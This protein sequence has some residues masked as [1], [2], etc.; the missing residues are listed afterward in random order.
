MNLTLMDW[1]GVSLLPRAYHQSTFRTNGFTDYER[2]TFS[3]GPLNLTFPTGTMIRLQLRILGSSDDDAVLA[4]NST[5]ANSRLEVRASPLIR[6]DAFELRDGSGATSVWSP[7]DSLVIR[8]NVSDPF[9]VAE[10]ADVRV[11]VTAPAGGTTV[12][13]ASIPVLMTDPAALPA[14]QLRELVLPPALANG[15]Y[16]VLVTALERNGVTDVATGDALVRAPRFTLEKD[17]TAANVKAGDRFH[18]LLWYNNTGT[19]PAGSVWINDSLPV[20][21][22]FVGSSEPGAMTGS[23]NWTW[24]SVGPGSFL[25]DIEVQVR[26][27]FVDPY[28]R[29]S[30]TLE[31]VDEKGYG[32][33]GAAASVEVVLRG[34]AI[35][36]SMTLSVPEVHANEPF[37]IQFRLTNT[38]EPAQTLWLNATVP[39]G[40]TYVSDTAASLGGSRS[41]FGSTVRFVLTGMPSASIWTFTMTLAGDPLLP[42]GLTLTCDATLEFTNENGASLPSKEADL[43]VASVAPFVPAASFQFSGTA[44]DPG[45]T[46][47]A[48][49]TWTNAGNEPAEDLWINLTLDPYLGLLDA[50][51]PATVGGGSVRFHST[52]VGLGDHGTFLNLTVLS[53]VPDRRNLVVGGVLDYTDGWGNGWP[54][55]T[56]SGDLLVATAPVLGLSVS[57]TNITVEAGTRVEYSIQHANAG[58]GTT[59]DVWLNLTLPASFVYVSDTSGTFAG[60]AGNE[61]RWHWTDQGPGQRSFLL[62]LQAKASVADGTQETLAFT[63]AYT[64]EGG[65]VRPRLSA[66]VTA[67]L[68]APAI[69]LT[70]E[71]DRSDPLPGSTFTYT[72][73]VRN[74]G[75]VAARNLW[76]LDSVDPRLQIVSY[77]SRVRASG[78]SDLN[79]TFSDLQPGQEETVVLVV[80]V[81]EGL[82]ARTPLANVAEAVYT[83][84]IGT[85][86]GYVRSAPVT[87]VIGF[88]LAP[89]LYIVLG[90]LA[91]GAAAVV[92]L[93]R[94]T[95]AAIEE[96]FL[97]YRDGVLIYHLSRS[98]VQEKDEDVLSGMLTA[99]QEF[100][101][102]AFRYGEHR[103]LHQLDF[104]DYRILIERG[105]TVY[106]AIVYSGKESTLVRRKVRGVLDNIEMAYADV[107]AGWDGDMD[108]MAGARDMIRDDLFHG[109]GRLPRPTRSA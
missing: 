60:I 64:D 19:G 72:I 105:K 55:P 71:A 102:D 20:Q 88:D 86:L 45:D 4:M 29:N 1:N 85:V 12:D 8:A 18:Y 109:N 63:L 75:S 62:V 57:P 98:L 103:E 54:R 5:F 10:I 73:R 83:N 25:L 84:G 100:V 32:W 42:Y 22:S 7:K 94:K 34:P 67:T 76:L 9:G 52:S 77:T 27:G 36:F 61:H 43:S 17:S 65:A 47:P 40:L 2:V 99:V 58:S 37:D 97:V 15:T 41:F 3:F 35:T 82:A 107:L 30:A 78:T 11:N 14:W 33:A 106:L 48:T 49:L 96:V 92:L 46:V 50:S 101:R 13:Y 108:K 24:M 79:W 81:A 51:E 70:L 104:G 95:Q 68:M 38:G 44:A 31:F 6:I 66:N 69:E 53:G 89:L 59:G 90:G 23:Y 87:V 91:I 80:R 56:F 93:L 39:S 16:Q 28:F 21:V 74:A 26:G